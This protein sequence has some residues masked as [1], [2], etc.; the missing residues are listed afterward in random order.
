MTRK[1]RVSAMSLNGRRVLYISYNGMLDPLGQSQ[2][3][4]YLRELARKGVEFTLLSFERGPAFDQ[5]G[6]AKRENLRLELA[7]DNIEWHCLRYH[8]RPSVPATFYDV[9]SGIRLGRRLVKQNRI[10]MV[11]ARSHIAAAIGLA[12][13][14]SF[15]LKLI[16]DVRGFMAEEYLDAGHWRDGGIPH[17]VTKT[18]ERRTLA[19]ADS[20]VTLTEKAW[21]IIREWDGLRGRDVIHEVVPCCTDLERFKFRPEDRERR[22]RELGL[23]NRFTLVYSGSIGSWYLS[24]KMADF[25]VQLLKRRPDA[26]FLWLTTGHPA[27]VR[28]VMDE[29]GIDQS[30]YTVQR[31]SSGDVPSYLSAADAGIAFYKPGPSKVATSPVKVSEYLANGLPIIINAGI[32]DSDNL[33]TDE[34]AGVLINSFDEA[35][36]TRAVTEIERFAGEVPSSRQRLSEIAAKLFDLR[37]VGIARYARLYDSVLSGPA[38]NDHRKSV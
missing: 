6:N 11:H 33:I 8:Q 32:G 21:P 30:Q 9:L 4:P 38:E 20:I 15:G 5:S 31:S 10:E 16:F 1:H 25:F 29:R 23:E 26:H 27:I 37:S 35:E 36:Y 34:Q 12:L 3:L 14:K 7:A 2:V 28:E 17:R 19:A 13:K 24:D 22:R 18:M